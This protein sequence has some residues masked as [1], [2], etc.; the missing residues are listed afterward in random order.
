MNYYIKYLKYK[1]KYLNLIGAGKQTAK[2]IF[3]G[4]IR[5][6]LN[7]VLPILKTDREKGFLKFTDGP[8]YED[9]FEQIFLKTNSDKVN[10]DWI[11]KSYIN[12]T[13]GIPSSLE[14]LGRFT[15]ALKEYNHL[16]VNIKGIAKDEYAG[17]KIIPINQIDGLVALEKYLDSD[18]NKQNVRLIEERKEKLKK[19]EERN[20][21]VELK[22]EE[23]IKKYGKEIGEDDKIIE[24]ETD[25]VIV[26]T[27]TTKEGSIFYGKNTRWCTAA[28]ENNMFD[29]YNG[30][31]PMHIIQSKTDPKLKFQ[32]HKANNE[33]KDSADVE[34]AESVVKISIKDDKLDEFFDN[35]LEIDLIKYKLKK[36]RITSTLTKS[37]KFIKI[38]PKLNHLEV[39]NIDT[40]DDLKDILKYLINL[41]E[42][43]FNHKYKLPLNDILKN[44]TKLEILRLGELF[45]QPLANSLSKLY[46][47]KEL[48][49]SSNFNQKLDNSLIGLKNLKKL[50]F[51]YNF[52]QELDNCFIDLNN[53]ESLNLGRSFNKPLNNSLFPL[54]KLEKLVL[55][56]QFN[57]PLGNSLKNLR[58]LKELELSNLFNH[59]LANSL[60]NLVNL[61]TLQLGNDFNQLLGFSLDS[62]KNLEKLIFGYD[63]NEPL[64]DSL[65]KLTNLKH[66]EFRHSFNQPLEKSFYNLINLQLLYFGDDFKQHIFDSLKNCVKLEVLAFGE[67]YN[68]VVDFKPLINLKTINL[69][70]SYKRYI[71]FKDLL[72]IVSIT[73]PKDYPYPIDPSFDKSKINHHLYN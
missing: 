12:N 32:I 45:N 21:K 13:F 42:L 29:Y 37:E 71:N 68:G 30:M 70:H 22:K 52:N 8:N 28:F 65:D 7:N 43:Y 40:S 6:N 47:L 9:I 41:K 53:L 54:K 11:I 14:N 67:F 62:L 72:N 3:M 5:N 66:I 64:Q 4:A 2:D 15:A 25:K 50:E 36:L 59:P 38:L 10:I 51:G 58:N 69:N 46:N 44:L 60:N 56:Y 73:I 23:E 24:L 18:E 16:K 48:E 39:V 19:K 1:R 27:P 33:L 49:M 61:K 63:F 35:V 55:G 34:I 20:K 31:G 26:Y 57:Q 17:R